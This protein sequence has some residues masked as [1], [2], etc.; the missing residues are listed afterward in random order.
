MLSVNSIVRGEI[1]SNFVELISIQ[2]S[3]TFCISN[4]TGEITPDNVNQWLA[5]PKIPS[6]IADRRQAFIDSSLEF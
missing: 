6:Q 4:H 5:L 2:I 3:I 1:D